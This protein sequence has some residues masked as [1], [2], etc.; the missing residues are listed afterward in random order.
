MSNERK[1]HTVIGITCLGLTLFNGIAY[2]LPDFLD[3][4]FLGLAIV[5]LLIGLFSKNEE[6]KKSKSKGK[7][8][9]K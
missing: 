8:K 4:L 3:G 2:T 7:N 1:L 5:F 6:K 9:K